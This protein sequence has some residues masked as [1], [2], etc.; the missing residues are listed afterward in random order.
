MSE[1]GRGYAVCLRQ[2]I[3][4]EPRLGE[5]VRNY[6]DLR[7]R[8]PDPDLFGP[9]RA[10]EMWADGAVD[11]LHDLVRPRRWVSK[12][13]WTQA[14]ALRDAMYGAKWGGRFDWG[15]ALTE[16]EVRDWIEVATRLLDSYAERAGRP[17][18]ATFDAAWALD[19]AAGLKPERGDA[20]TCEGP[21]PTR[22]PVP[23]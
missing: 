16:G 12:A 13:E 9:E 20:A 1:F 5:Y 19:E 8:H 3:W 22:K 10:I 2:F 15:G 6:T 23:A 7:K 4:H 11:H 14:K 21:I 18:P 17:R